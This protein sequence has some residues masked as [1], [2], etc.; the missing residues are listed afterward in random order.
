MSATSTLP[1]N[2]IENHIRD[3]CIHTSNHNRAQVKFN[4][5]LTLI[6]QEVR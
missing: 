5:Q 6:N 3:Q 2:M 1:A 4:N